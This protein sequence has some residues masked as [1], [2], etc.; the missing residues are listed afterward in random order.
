[1]Y[2]DTKAPICQTRMMMPKTP[3]SDNANSHYCLPARAQSIRVTA[4]R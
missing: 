4:S 3:D 2:I 1:M